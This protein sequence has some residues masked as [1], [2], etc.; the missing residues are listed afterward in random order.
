M[1]TLTIGGVTYEIVDQRARDLIGN[2]DDLETTGKNSLVAAINEI[3]RTGGGGEVNPDDVTKI[4]EEYL[5]ENPPGQGEPGKDGISPTITIDSITGGHRITISDAN[6]E[7]SFDVKDGEDGYTPQ[8]GVDYFTPEDIAAIAEEA[9][10]LVDTGSGDGGT[11]SEGYEAV[12][13]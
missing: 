11:S 10:K 5:A 13:F 6:G 1:K 9:A 2:L 7:K 3:A 8:K 12:E 4:V